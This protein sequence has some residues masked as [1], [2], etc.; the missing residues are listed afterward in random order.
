MKAVTVTPGIPQSAKLTEVPTPIAGPGEVRVE[1][2]RVGID[3][4]DVE[5]D[6]ALYGEAPGGEGHLIVGHESLGRVESV[7]AG[8]SGLS[9]GDLV[10]AMVRR[11]DQCA[12][13]RNGEQDMCVTGQYTER[14][15]KGR[16]GY[17]AQYYVERPEHIVKLST[18][19]R[20]VGVLLEPLTVVEK[21]VRHGWKLQERMKMWEPKRALIL[22]AGPIGLL[23]AMLMRLRGIDTTVYARDPNE[24]I[25]SRVN[26][27][28]ARYISK[29]DVNGATVNHLGSLP[30][31]YGPFD[32]VLE[33]TGAPSVA[34]GAMRLAGPDGVVCLASVTGGDVPMEICASCLNLELV[35]GNRVIFGTV[36]ANRIDFENGVRDLAR[37][38]EKWPGWLE[39]MITRRVPL[40]RFREAFERRPGDMKVVVEIN[41]AT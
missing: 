10:V 16:H 7:G 8:V 38:V 3:G 19:V 26:E 25:A 33:A 37:A 23:A 34:M 31:D 35:L 12:P 17:L 6:R 41:A 2:I 40:E 11:P 1:V 18:A 28:G 36:N 39:K 27:L 24:Q 9:V 15:I 14:G 29:L 5:I 21:G 13:C 20:D 22:G 4:T 32:F 30:S